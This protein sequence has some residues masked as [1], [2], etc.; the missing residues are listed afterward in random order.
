MAVRQ[1]KAG[2]TVSQTR[3]IVSSFVAGI[4]AMALAGLVFS[5]V[6]DGGIAHSA[7]AAPL[8]GRQAPAV[9]PLDVAAVK[10]QL[11]QADTAVQVAQDA[12]DPAV[13]RLGELAG[14]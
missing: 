12:T 11:A 13:F 3:M 14:E 9:Q 7:H 2:K 1:P 8:R 6:A 10:A 4:G 5:V